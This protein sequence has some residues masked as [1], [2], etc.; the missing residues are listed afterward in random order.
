MVAMSHARTWALEGEAPTL[1]AVL[2]P[3]MARLTGTRFQQTQSGSI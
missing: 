3:V 2:T 1:K